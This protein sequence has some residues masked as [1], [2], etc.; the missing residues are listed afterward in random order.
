VP[1]NQLGLGDRPDETRGGEGGF[2]SIS[3]S[4]SDRHLHSE[5]KTFSR[6]VVPARD[7]WS[8]TN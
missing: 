2:L 8:C 5:I 3:Y 1:E 4:H 6:E 7:N